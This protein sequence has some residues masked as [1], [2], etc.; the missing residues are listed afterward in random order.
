[1]VWDSGVQDNFSVS[2]RVYIFLVM[3]VFALASVLYWRTQLFLSSEYVEMPLR[4][5]ETKQ[6]LILKQ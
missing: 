2:S 6:E 5:L 4:G 1:M 3:G